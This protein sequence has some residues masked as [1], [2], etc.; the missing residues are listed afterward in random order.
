MHWGDD[1]SYDKHI[2]VKGKEINTP[3]PFSYILVIRMRGKKGNLLVI[4]GAILVG[5]GFLIWGLYNSLVYIPSVQ[6]GSTEGF[7]PAILVLTFSSILVVIGL[8]IL[9][10]K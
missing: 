9:G 1:I 8:L 7:V 10:N 4:I 5:L 3:S 6:G 2:K